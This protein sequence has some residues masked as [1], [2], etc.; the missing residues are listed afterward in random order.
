MLE[1]EDFSNWT[2]MHKNI[3]VAHIE[4]IEEEGVVSRVIKTHHLKHSPIGTLCDNHIS[5]ERRKLNA[6]L[7]KRAIPASRENIDEVLDH[8]DMQNSRVLLLQSFGLSLSDQYWL[9]PTALHTKWEDVNFFQN[10]FSTDIGEIIF[11]NKQINI[12]E[13]DFFSP[14]SSLNGW[15]EKKWIIKNN[16][17][18]LVKGSNVLYRQ[19]PYNEKIASDIMKHLNINHIPYELTTIKDKPY[20]LCDCFVDADTEFI[21]AMS[22]VTHIPQK[23]NDTKLTHLLRGCEILGMDPQKIKTDIDKMIVIDYLVANY[24]RHWGNFGFIRDA[25]TLKW[26]GFALIFDTGASLWQYSEQIDNTVKSRSFGR[27]QSEELALITD[28][29]WYT[30]IPEETLQQIITST[31]EKHPRMQPERINKIAN[32]VIERANTITKLKN[33]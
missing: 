17:R 7:R 32:K 20:S 13:I 25:N 29:S 27:Y 24:D 10:H 2:L 14:D 30:P 23:E 1:K 11:D 16:K 33:V 21:T 28:L 15:L 26:Q 9:K 6:W 4:M 22:I 8:L 19:E 18:I 12:S 5:I 3:P 31:L